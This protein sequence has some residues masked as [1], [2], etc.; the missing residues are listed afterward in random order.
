MLDKIQIIL[1]EGAYMP[2]RAFADDA[3]LDLRTPCD[4]TVP[5]NGSKVIDTKTCL[6]IPKGYWG[7]LESKSGLNIRRDVVSLGGTID[8]GYQDSIK[9]KLYNFGDDEYIFHAGDKIVQIVI[10]PCETGYVLEQVDSFQK[11]DRGL[12]GIGSSGV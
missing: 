3:G 7:K 8:A 4:V 5:A 1:Q 6:L 12:N 11:T 10:M 2:I 9:V